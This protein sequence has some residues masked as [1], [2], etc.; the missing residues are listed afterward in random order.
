MSDGLRGDHPF[1]HFGSSDDG[2]ISDFYDPRQSPPKAIVDSSPLQPAMDKNKE[3]LKVKLMVR[4]PFEQLVEQGI[5]PPLKTSPAIHEQCKQLE[6][7][8]TGDLLKAK[9]QQRPNRE[10]LE[11][12]HIL[13]HD[14]IHVDPSLAERQRMLKKARLADHL[15]SQIQHRPGVLELIKKNILH[16]EKPIEKIVKDGYLP[17]KATSEGLLTRPQHPSKYINLEDDSQSSESDT[18]NTPPRITT[19]TSNVLEDATATSTG[20]VTVAV[21][22][23]TTDGQLVVTTAPILQNHAKFQYVS[24]IPPPPPPPPTTINRKTTETSKLFEKLCQSVTSSGEISPSYMPII[25]SP[26]SLGSTASTLSPLSSIASP[27]QSLTPRPMVQSQSPALQII[28]Q[29]KTDAPGKEKNRKKSKCKPVSKKKEIK[30]HEYKGPPNAQK[31]GACGDNGTPK[32]TPY[33]LAV[34]QQTSFLKCLETFTKD[35]SINPVTTTPIQNDS[36]TTFSIIPQNPRPPPMP[37]PALSVC[38][39][40]PPPSPAT[41]YAESMCSSMYVSTPPVPTPNSSASMNGIITDIASLE[42]MKVSNLKMHLKKRN[43]LVSGSKTILIGRLKEAL[44]SDKSSSMSDTGSSVNAPMSPESVVMSELS[45]PPETMEIVPMVVPSPQPQTATIV[46]QS[47]EDMIREKERTIDELKRKLAE[48]TQELNNYKMQQ[49]PEIPIVAQKQPIIQNVAQKPIQLKVQLVPTQQP[50]LKPTTTM[51]PAVTP[52]PIT[53]KMNIKKQLEA[54]IQRKEAAKA[55]QAMEKAAAT[56]KPPQSQPQQ[57]HQPQPQ[58]QQSQPQTQ[59]FITTTNFKPNYG[60]MCSEGTIILVPM[61]EKQQSGLVVKGNQYLVQQPMKNQPCIKTTTA[62][63]VHHIPACLSNPSIMLSA[64]PQP[65]PP[66]PPVHVKSE[67]LTDV[68]DILIKNGDL[69]ESALNTPTTATTPNGNNVIM[70][71]MHG[72]LIFPKQ[73]SKTPPLLENIDM[74]SPML[75][76]EPL[77]KDKALDLFL[78]SSHKESD[79]YDELELF[80]LMNSHL[81]MDIEEQNSNTSPNNN[82]LHSSHNHNN[83]ATKLTRRDMNPSLQPSLNELIKQEQQQQENPS[84]FVDIFESLCKDSSKL[85][86]SDNNANN[87]YLS[88]P[89]DVCDDFDFSLP[90]FSPISAI[91]TSPHPFA[92][93]GL[94]ASNSSTSAMDSSQP[95]SSGG[96]VSSGGNGGIMM[97]NNDILDFLSIEDYK[98][99]SWGEGDFVCMN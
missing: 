84:S 94:S 51:N 76:E 41:S 60:V 20:I 48:T 23:P 39:S 12:R 16:T 34:H 89:M 79:A 95:T 73:D 57:Q 90:D 25:A 21:T 45:P 49:K 37:S 14:E 58:Q 50:V 61:L 11:R 91:N 2:N 85:A 81:D 17:F 38:S 8:K 13:E 55:Q 75:K 24:H 59:T 7:A 88:T 35:P 66:P 40:I 69:P 62:N 63:V 47:Q 28:P 19:K 74:G 43:L 80:G 92:S 5:I 3:S 87:N 46:M 36:M 67:N 30:F 27:P 9:I 10:E 97:N 1:I 71:D 93:C 6:R 78:K 86:E 72:N 54:K 64:P 32:E 98:M 18:R 33:Q 22:I 56:K 31:G 96:G 99:S 44:E 77:D 15:N 52:T 42:K 68:L 4:R 65:P 70:T 83:N 82:H 53:Q 29:F 26:R